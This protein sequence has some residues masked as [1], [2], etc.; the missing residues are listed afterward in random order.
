MRIP[1]E[2][3]EGRLSDAQ[4]A[5]YRSLARNAWI[6]GSAFALALC[7]PAAI[8]LSANRGAPLW[9][10]A[11][12]GVTCAACAVAF[13]YF[14]MWRTAEQIRRDATRG[15]VATLIEGQATHGNLDMRRV[16]E[17]LKIKA[18][19][20]ALHIGGK[21]LAIR[22][23]ELRAAALAACSEP[24]A[25]AYYLP[26]E[27]LHPG[28]C[29]TGSA[30][31]EQESASRAR[32]SHVR[33]TT[34]FEVVGVK[35]STRVR[36]AHARVGRLGPCGRLGGAPRDDGA[37]VG[38][39]VVAASARERATPIAG[40]PAA[41][42]RD[43]SAKAARPMAA[44]RARRELVRHARDL[45]ARGDLRLG[46]FF[47][48]ANAI[49]AA[50]EGAAFDLDRASVLYQERVADL[51]RALRRHPPE[52]AVPAVFADLSYAG[53]PGG[54]MGDT[55]I[56]ESGSCE[57][58]SHLI[59]A[60]LYDAGHRD[61]RF[62]YYGGASAGVTHLAPVLPTKNGERDLVTGTPSTP[63]GASFGADE[64]IDAYA[65]AHG[66]DDDPARV[67]STN[68][69]P[70]SAG[71]G[72]ADGIAGSTADAA[73][74][75][76]GL[77][78]GIA[79]PTR[80]MTAG[81]PENP[82]HFE[83]ALPLYAGRAVSAPLAPGEKADEP[84][85][86]PDYSANCSFLVKPGELDP[87]AALAASGDDGVRIDLYR[88]PSDEELE[89]V[90]MFVAQIDEAKRR[91]GMGKEERVVLDGCLAALY[92]RAS[93]E[94]ALA[95]ERAVATR[96]ALEG[97]DARRD[98]GELITSLALDTDEG[99]AALD[100]IAAAYGGGAWVLLFLPGGDGPA[101]RLAKESGSGMTFEGVTL[102]TFTPSSTLRR[103]DARST[104]PMPSTSTDRSKSCTSSRTP[105]T[106][107]ARG[108]P[109]IA[110]SFPKARAPRARSSALT[111]SSCP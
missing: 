90:S 84:A 82:D 48:A 4:Q 108:R 38:P 106:T 29:R 110:W 28:R 3:R 74:D 95:G 49:D 33:L 27:S 65:R 94:F 60:T 79:T 34:A 23:G 8:A 31:G 40:N 12:V 52:D 91:T 73:G 50:E 15:A 41:L 88:A 111:R 42:V 18:Q 105:T 68:G 89:R 32:S 24:A 6:T 45:R 26:E 83:G 87:P 76:R 78:Q 25:R 102:L 22:D 104:S 58:L 51:T 59:V 96:A 11:A 9:K 75:A 55:L 30:R 109:A 63:G 37:L 5:H 80:S 21:R 62:R 57:P 56:S 103:A 71:G 43:A 69:R 39:L 92:D 35:P 36:S 53:L 47:L 77:F 19:L 64:I 107:R 85:A 81:Y 14:K 13:A 2:N 66:V 20:V 72:G 99:K 61:V 86:I 100:R 67:A 46:A 7:L 101:L 98:G 16:T 1:P 17:D 10:R 70:S 97:A 44:Q 93:I 54:R